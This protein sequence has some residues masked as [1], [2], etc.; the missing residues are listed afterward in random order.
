MAVYV[1]S[2]LVGFLPNGVDNAQ[3]TRAAYFRKLPVPVKYVYS[4]CV[5]EPYIRNYTRFGIAAE[6]MLS[7]HQFFTDQPSL[8]GEMKSSELAEKLS[9]QLHAVRI[10][11]RN[12]E[13][14]L[15]TEQGRVACIL[16]KEDGIHVQYVNYYHQERLLTQ[17]IYAGHVLY[18]N[19]YV[20]ARTAEGAAYAKLVRRSFKNTDGST[21]FDILIDQ[22][23]EE[24]YL[25]P[26]GWNGTKTEF[27]E[28]FICSLKLS[29]EDIIFIDRPADQEYTQA[30]FRHSGG[31]KICVFLHSMH[32]LEKNEDPY[33]IGLNHEYYYWFAQSARIHTFLVSTEEQKV[34]LKQKLEEYGCPVPEIE[35]IPVS[36]LQKL[37]YPAE[38]R[39]PY[40]MLSVSRLDPRKR[41]DWV[42][43]AAVR[44]Q[45]KVPQLQLDLYGT[46]TVEY[47]RRVETL[48]SELEAESF[49]HLKGFC[50]V[51]EVYQHYEVYVTASLWETL[52]LSL[53]EA[54]GAGNAMIGLDAHYGNRLFIRDG[55]NGILIPFS[56][57][58]VS[59]RSEEEAL[60]E[61]M[62]DAMAEILQDREGLQSRSKESYRI[63]ETYLNQYLED[64]WL[65]FMEGLL[66]Q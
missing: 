30:L 6:E 61:H 54:A 66:T 65:H 38:N 25:F 11:E 56:L 50:D 37:S 17:E 24:R 9:T 59:S 34:E 29:E 48:V 23:G 55:V 2:L 36:G 63:A 31:A 52:G 58:A 49:I 10:E 35:A 15:F 5:Y 18:T 26:D 13:I 14:N 41:I 20:T 47:V 32:Y 42:I 28:K 7:A 19:Y 8:A 53:M 45:K 22:K 4:D 44:A 60:I 16:K 39:K 62:A 21:A 51:S 46:G 64:K 40:S 12:R 27:V 43:R 33:S 1:F 57:D 3:G